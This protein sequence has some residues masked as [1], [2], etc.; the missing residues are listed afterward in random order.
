MFGPRSCQECCAETCSEVTCDANYAK[1][2]ELKASLMGFGRENHRKPWVFT[3]FFTINISGQIITTSLRPHWKSWLVRDIIPIIAL[4][5]VCELL[6]FTQI[7]GFPVRFPDFPISQSHDPQF[8]AGFRW[9]DLGEKI[10]EKFPEEKKTPADF[11]IVFGRVAMTGN[12][13]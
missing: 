7:Y 6:S 11:E 8:Q 1:K 2:S 13:H 4:F 9:C 5:Q 10:S 3:C 12:T